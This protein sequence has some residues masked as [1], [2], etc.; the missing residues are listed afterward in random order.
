MRL[1]QKI[2]V[3]PGRSQPVKS[4]VCQKPE[5]QIVG[6]ALDGLEAIQKAEEL[7]PDLISRMLRIGS[8]L[9]GEPL[10]ESHFARHQCWKISSNRQRNVPGWVQSAGSHCGGLFPPYCEETARTSK[11]NKN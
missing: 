2:W 9:V 11:F 5:L 3:E 7:Q 8:L 6:E 4:T 1:R 10:V